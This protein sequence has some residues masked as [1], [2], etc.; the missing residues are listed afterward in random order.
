MICDGG[1]GCVYPIVDYQNDWKVKDKCSK[2]HEN[3]IG[4]GT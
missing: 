2:T 1:F 3:V 4:M